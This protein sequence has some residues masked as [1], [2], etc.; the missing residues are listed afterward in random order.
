[1]TS[2]RAAP[3]NLVYLDVVKAVVLAHNQRGWSPQSLSGSGPTIQTEP[4]QMTPPVEGSATSTSTL[5]VTWSTVS[6]LNDG[7]SAVTSYNLYWDQ[8]IGSWVTLVGQNS[9]YLGTSYTIGVGIMQGAT[10][11]FKVRAENM[12]GFGP[13]STTT[14]IVA[15]TVPSQVTNVTT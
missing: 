11:S 13:F 15:S 3:F 7:G 10:Y 2:L 12:W 5:E 6:S 9:S 8:G 1:M 4:L 14:S